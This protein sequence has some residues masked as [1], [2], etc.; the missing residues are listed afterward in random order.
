MKKKSSYLTGPVRNYDVWI[1]LGVCLLIQLVVVQQLIP[2][3]HALKPSFPW[4]TISFILSTFAY[5]IPL[6][7]LSTRYGCLKR[8]DFTLRGQDLIILF[9]ASLIVFLAAA[10]FVLK[11]GIRVSTDITQ[12][13]SRLSAFEYVVVY[14]I[15]LLLGP[16]LEETF[17][18]RYIFELLKS[19][20][21]LPLSILLTVGFETILHIGYS[22]EQLIIIFIYSFLF[23]IV[24][25]KSRLVASVIIHC[26]INILFSFP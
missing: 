11:Y 26:L 5:I 20:Y 18:R 21:R 22:F 2:I 4:I 1:S 6:F 16:F 14:F 10:V 23:T 3:Y 24:Y 17:F 12:M 9:A 25:L 7:Y 15:I 19:K 13:V 8:S